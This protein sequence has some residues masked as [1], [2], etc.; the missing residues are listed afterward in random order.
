MGEFKEVHVPRRERQELRELV[1]LYDKAVRD[2]AR[3]RTRLRAKY[4]QHGVPTPG[5]TV[6][7]KARREEWLQKVRRPTVRFMLE[8]LYRKLDD[9]EAAA[10]Q[11]VRRENHFARRFREMVA[12]GTRPGMARRTVARS[13]LA[14]ALAMWK[15]GTEYR[16][17]G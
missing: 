12:G 15:D 13:I 8:V 16:D 5:T 3:A 11:A 1:R 4:R 7:S 2:T 17:A 10:E 6:Y 9:A 14:A